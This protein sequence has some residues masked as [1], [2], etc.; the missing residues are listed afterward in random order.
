LSSGQQ[1]YS[2]LK[3]ELDAANA[4]IADLEATLQD[5]ND[6]ICRERDAANAR[7]EA[8]EADTHCR[9]MLQQKA[10]S[11][12][13]ALR[14][15]VEHWKSAF[16]RSDEKRRAHQAAVRAHEKHGARAEGEV[17]ALRAE[18]ERLRL[19]IVNADDQE[20][21]TQEWNAELQSSLAVANALLA[22]LQAEH[23]ELSRL[24]S[25]SVGFWEPQLGK[26]RAQLAAANALLDQDERNE[27]TGYTLRQELRRVLAAQ[28]ATAPLDADQVAKACCDI[29]WNN[30]WV[31]TY[32]LER[33]Q[34]PATAPIHNCDSPDCGTCAGA[35]FART[36]PT[37]TEA[38]CCDEC[39]TIHGLG[40]TNRLCPKASDY[41][42]EL[43][44]KI[45]REWPEPTRTEAEQRVIDAMAAVPV[46]G[47]APAQGWDVDD[48]VGKPA[49]APSRFDG[50]P[51]FDQPATAQTDN[52]WPVR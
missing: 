18:V 12:A 24:H 47:T 43:E 23:T 52:G 50:Y 8:A 30:G 13:A 5:C 9:Y 14:A 38:E 16:S 26:M 40:N 17:S 3:D 4:R 46:Q 35:Y 51:P 6:D 11:E 22:R 7:A 25:H 21:E 36:A 19:L 27:I 31:L 1:A 33:A 39:G 32:K 20:T 41:S 2:E 49:T 44:A 45:A 29:A 28:P 15:E 10:E 37:R 42:P 34:Q 48:L